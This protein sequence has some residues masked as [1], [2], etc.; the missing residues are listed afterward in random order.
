MLHA[1]AITSLN[2]EH[3]VLDLYEVEGLRYQRT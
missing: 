1:M 3:T 2:F